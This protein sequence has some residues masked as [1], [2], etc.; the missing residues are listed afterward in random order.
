MQSAAAE[1]T[2]QT[3]K[4]G[5]PAKVLFPVKDSCPTQNSEES[6]PFHSTSHYIHAHHIFDVKMFFFQ[7]GFISSE[8]SVGWN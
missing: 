6:M 5:L 7:E 2:N 8:V 1:C 4:A 3:T